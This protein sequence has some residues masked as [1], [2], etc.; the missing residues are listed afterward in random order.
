MSLDGSGVSSNSAEYTR[1]TEYPGCRYT[2]CLATIQRKYQSIESCMSKE[3]LECRLC[4]MNY[5]L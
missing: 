3:R 4:Y 1:D 5:L 2:G